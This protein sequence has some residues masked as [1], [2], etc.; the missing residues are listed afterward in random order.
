LSVQTID[1]S[2]GLVAGSQM[3]HWLEFV[4]QLPNRLQSIRNSAERA[5]L[6][7][8]FGDGHYDRLRVD[9]ETNKA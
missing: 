7:G 3:L 9:I 4:N 1:G 6:S 8:R 5:H 2:T